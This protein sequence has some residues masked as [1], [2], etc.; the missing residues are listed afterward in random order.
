MISFLV[1]VILISLTGV[2]APG[3]VTAATLA[4]GSRDRW[5]G[6]WLAVGHGIVEI[7]LIFILI[8]G[9]G[10]VLKTDAAKIGIGVVGGAF[11]VY[12]GA[13]TFREPAASG[14]GAEKSR[15]AGPL[16]T[17]LVLSATNPYFL[18]WWATVGLNLALQAKGFG[19]YAI[20]IFAAVHWTCDLIWLTILSLT[21]FGGMA[22]LSVKNQKWILG[23]CGIAMAAFGLKFLYGAIALMAE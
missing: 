7:P 2:M 10:T 8:L 18:F 19:L 17:G 6:V 15:S 22:I 14:P 13:M 12:L 5:A 20:V 11:L 3:A 9:L 1:Q 4:Q 23:F 16:L 21:A